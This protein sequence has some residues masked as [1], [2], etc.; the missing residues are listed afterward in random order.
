M[1]FSSRIAAFGVIPSVIFI[2]GLITSI[3][4]LVSAQREFDRYINTEQ[5]VERSLTD[6][7]AQGLQMGQAMRNILLDPQNLKAFDNL[8]AAQADYDKAFVRAQQS[9]QGRRA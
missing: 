3:G 4:A 8:K 9:R 7:Y 1:K 5:A 6:M 2:V